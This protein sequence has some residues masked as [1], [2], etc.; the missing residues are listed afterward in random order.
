MVT[1]PEYP[2][3]APVPDFAE[4]QIMANEKVYA[5][6]GMQGHNTARWAKHHVVK[7]A[8]KKVRRREAR[9]RAEED[10]Q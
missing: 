7:T 6:P 1:G 10:K 3:G 8:A 9:M 4:I 2:T 5:K